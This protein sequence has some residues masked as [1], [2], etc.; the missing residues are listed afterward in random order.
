MMV[1]NATASGDGSSKGNTDTGKCNSSKSGSADL[2]LVKHILKDESAGVKRLIANGAQ[3]ADLQPPPIVLAALHGDFHMV[4]LLVNNGANV[5]A[6]I[7]MPSAESG[8]SVSLELMEGK[9]ALHFAAWS[10]NWRVAHILLRAGANPNVRL[11]S[12][13]SLKVLPRD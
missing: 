13:L 6:G 11:K 7:S 9:R 10:G 1:M 4:G 3:T 2:A 12:L 5:N 8:T